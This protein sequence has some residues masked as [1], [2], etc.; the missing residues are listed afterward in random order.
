MIQRLGP[1][2]DN[3][4]PDF[5]AALRA[6]QTLCGNGNTAYVPQ[7]DDAYYAGAGLRR[8]PLHRVV[9]AGPSI[10]VAAHQI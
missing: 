9:R 6:A 8:E 10:M 7:C 1:R 3:T 5:N 4:Y 2:W